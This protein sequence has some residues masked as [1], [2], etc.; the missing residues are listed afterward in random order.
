VIEHRSSSAS[1]WL[2][3]RRFR[4][5]L[6]I[7]LIEG[8]LVILGVIDRWVATGIAVV[9]I[10]LYFLLG[11]GANSPTVRQVSWVAAVSQAILILVP[12]V[13]AIIG[14]VALVLVAIIAVVAL[15]ALFAE[16]PS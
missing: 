7:A 1:L 3:E 10:A 4:T 9:I 15:V 8:L 13:F 2:R 16:R 14:T 12:I 6:W 5:A 11:R